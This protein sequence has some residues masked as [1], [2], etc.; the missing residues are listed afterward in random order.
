[1]EDVHS[2]KWCNVRSAFDEN[3]R[4]LATA[5][6]QVSAN[7]SVFGGPECSFWK[8]L[9]WNEMF[10]HFFGAVSDVSGESLES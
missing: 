4:N 8:V 5:L 9:L 6:H 10:G 3:R 7:H 1:M 2:Y